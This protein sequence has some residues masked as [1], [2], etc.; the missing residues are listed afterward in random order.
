MALAY[1]CLSLGTV[2]SLIDVIAQCFCINIET[3]VYFDVFSIYHVLVVTN[4]PVVFVALY[5]LCEFGTCLAEFPNQTVT[6]LSF[7]ILYIAMFPGYGSL[8]KFLFCLS[9]FFFWVVRF[10]VFFLFKQ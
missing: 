10:F 9:F 7:F 5:E 3:D 4:L 8:P 6:A 2:F 1:L